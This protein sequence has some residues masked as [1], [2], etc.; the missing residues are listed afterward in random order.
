M[1]VIVLEN[2]AQIGEEL[3]KFYVDFVNENTTCYR[4][5]VFHISYIPQQADLQALLSR[6]D[7]REVWG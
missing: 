3:G 6:R 2:A 4:N 1:K 5:S 7:V